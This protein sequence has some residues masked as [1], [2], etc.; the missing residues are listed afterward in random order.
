MSAKVAANN[1]DP[2][3]QRNEKEEPICS[4]KLKVEPY[5]HDSDKAESSHL[6]YL[7]R[8]VTEDPAHEPYRIAG[9]VVT[10]VALVTAIGSVITAGVMWQHAYDYKGKGADRVLYASLYIFTLVESCLSFVAMLVD[11]SELFFRPSVVL[12]R[13][14][15]DLKFAG[16]CVT[17]LLL[18]LGAIYSFIVPIVLKDRQPK[19]SAALCIIPAVRFVALIIFFAILIIDSRL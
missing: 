17:V 9:I 7:H 18:C 6:T 12:I 8:M 2:S 10:G 3:D 14:R 19:T 16:R 13:D 11:F 1:E 4:E 15:T 5:G